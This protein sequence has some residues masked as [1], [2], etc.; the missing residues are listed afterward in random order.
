MQTTVLSGRGGRGGSDGSGG[1][2][3]QLIRE[4]CINPWPEIWKRACQRLQAGNPALAAELAGYP[5]AVFGLGAG[6]FYLPA[7][8]AREWG[9]R[10]EDAISELLTVLALG[11]V[12]YAFQDQVVDE[13]GAPASMCLISDTALLGYLDGLA[14]LVPARAAR[15]RELHDRA[16]DVYCAAVLRDLGH[17][18]GLVPYSA[19]ELVRLGEKAAPGAVAF[20]LAADL[21]GVPELA[22]LATTS[23]LRL[24]TGLQ[25]VDDL[26]DAAEDARTGNRTWPVTAALLSYPGLDPMDG[27]GVEAAVVGSGVAAAGLRLAAATFRDA[28]RYART[29]G[30]LV[31][32]E[33][34]EEWERRVE[35]QERHLS[36]VQPA[37]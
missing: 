18:D 31:V 29:A 19:A 12:H 9:C 33:L 5:P 3:V 11:H 14:A 16:Y 4:Q 21:A 26:H 15:Y 32:R 6:F 34:A 23:V 22:D 7:A 27:G 20:H 28:A 10:D 35:E 2:P 13:G 24:C 30:S 17:R 36:A 37:G 8:Q 1:L 25:L